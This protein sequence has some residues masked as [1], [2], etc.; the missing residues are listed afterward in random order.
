MLQNQ[1]CAEP[2]FWV[3]S[4]LDTEPTERPSGSAV[5]GAEPPSLCRESEHSFIG[6][7]S[8]KNGSGGG[9]IATYLAAAVAIAV[10]RAAANLSKGPWPFGGPPSLMVVRGPAIPSCAPSRH[11]SFD[12]WESK[13]KWICDSEGVLYNF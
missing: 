11:L 5:H 1:G 7:K 6:G 8:A 3:L 4:V 13:V 12:I 10:T 2:G 9:G